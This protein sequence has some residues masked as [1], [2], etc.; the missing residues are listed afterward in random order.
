MGVS[1]SSSTWC[2]ASGMKRTCRSVWASPLFRTQAGHDSV[3]VLCGSTEVTSPAPAGRGEGLGLAGSCSSLCSCSLFPL[4]L[5]LSFFL[6]CLHF[7]LVDMSM[8]RVRGSSAGLISTL[9]GAIIYI[10]RQARSMVWPKDHPYPRI[11]YVGI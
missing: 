2:F 5:S 3:A 6:R 8:S 4:S 10:N 11:N 1:C 9:Y 7:L